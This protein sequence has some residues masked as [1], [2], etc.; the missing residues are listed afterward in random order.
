MI[1]GKSR[2]ILLTIMTQDNIDL[3]H[4]TPL[5]K[6]IRGLQSKLI[7][8]TIAFVMIAEV[9]AFVPSVA[10]MRLR[11]IE[12]RLDNAA[13]ASLV[14]DGQKNITLSEAVQTDTLM[15]T[16]TKSIV[17]RKD[18]ESRVIASV[19]GPLSVDDHLNLDELGAVQAM[20]DAFDTL[21]F[22]G[23]RTI[24]VFGRVADEDNIQIELVMEDRQLRHAMLIYSRNVLI[25]SMIIAFI[26]SGLLFFALNKLMIGPI[27]RI[28]RSM[29]HFSKEP[30]DA[31]RI[32]KPRDGNDELWLAEQHL[33]LMQTQLHGTIKQQKRLAELGLAV[34]KINHDMRNIL[35]SAQLLSDRM[36]NIDDP[37]F[38]RLAPKLLQTIDRALGYSSSVLDYGK[39]SEPEP[40][41]QL[42]R[43]HILVDDVHDS[44]AP[45]IENSGVE[46]YNHVTQ[47]LEIEAD[48]EQF[49]RVLTNISRNSIE[50]LSSLD[51]N[52]PALVKQLAIS[53]GR[54]HNDDLSIF[55]D[56]TG[57]GMPFK[58]KE[59]LFKPFRGSARAG[60]TGLGLAIAKELVEAHGGTIRLVD[61]NS[62][63]TQF[64][65]RLPKRGDAVG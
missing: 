19:D 10:N 15:A 37:L 32:M 33:C 49:V 43:L 3:R 51:P 52:D 21:L 6:P 63:G 18:G 42:L 57:P 40:K 45:Q 26:T 53:A 64:E 50:A 61:K 4:I 23:D 28:T 25:I 16:G 8:L 35:T 55:I 65:I 7:I 9:L 46:F 31:S 22:G 59:H 39:A 13:A 58:A 34:S 2:Q 20:T 1:I 48:R 27:Q 54:N 36:A 41:R 44:L 14:V 62:A 60:G 11:W 5:S 24:C 29:Q 12:D 38:K 30:E 47:D 17:L 56:D